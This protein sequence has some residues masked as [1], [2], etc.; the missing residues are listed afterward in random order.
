MAM[1]ERAI[2]ISSSLLMNGQPH[3]VYGEDVG[4]EREREREMEEL[5]TRENRN[6]VDDRILP[7]V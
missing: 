5:V 2:S 7:L 4:D 6:G 3:S 1:L